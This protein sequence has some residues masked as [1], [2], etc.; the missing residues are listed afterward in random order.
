MGFVFTL[1]P[2]LHQLAESAEGRAE[3]EAEAIELLTRWCR[4]WCF[5]GR[6]VTIGGSVSWHPAGD[7]NPD[8]WSPHL[9]VLIPLRGLDDAGV[10]HEGRFWVPDEA[11]RQLQG[12]W[13]KRLA[14]WGYTPGIGPSW[15]VDH[16][17]RRHYLS[18]ADQ[19]KRDRAAGR[20]PNPSYDPRGAAAAYY[21]RPFPGWAPRIFRVRYWGNVARWATLEGVEPIR[22]PK[23]SDPCN[24]CEKCGGPMRHVPPSDTS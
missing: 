15:Y 7:S 21:H 18:A 19:A 23:K 20:K 9:N 11:M 14:W 4:S 24:V 22:W 16:V 1:P 3:I 17:H 8:H 5:R 6:Q 2:A 12:E 13:I 10:A